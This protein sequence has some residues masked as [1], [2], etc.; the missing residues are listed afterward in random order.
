MQQKFQ[1]AMNA[2]RGQ[3]IPELPDEILLLEKEITSKFASIAVV[4]EIIEKNATLSGA[5]L[6]IVNSPVVKLAEPLSSIR[7]AVNILGLD[8]IYNLVVAAAVQNLFGGQGLLKDIMDYSVDVAFCMAD[9]SEWVADV[10]R[11]EAY[12]LGLFHNVGAMMLASQ[13]EAKYDGL[14]RSSMSIPIL[15]LKKEEAIY[16][17]NHAIIGVL[18]GKKWHL[19]TEMLNAIML[20]HNE[21][22]ERI[23]N[24]NVRAMVAMIKVA[25]GIVSEI[26][27]GAY[28]SAEMRDYEKDGM[29]ELM[30]E[31]HV[32]KEIRT[33]LMSYTFKD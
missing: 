18:V 10:S 9:I 21:K 8:N 12:M 2:I 13:D 26:S 16:G 22:C 25:S 29:Q 6:K 28:R 31:D 4:A 24:D 5:V 23:K 7:E 27:L 19:P 30:L 32:V 3:S 14:F 1:N 11:D 17:S 15:S 20:H 33:A